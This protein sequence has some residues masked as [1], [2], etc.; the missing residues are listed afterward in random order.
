[1]NEHLQSEQPYFPELHKEII[2]KCTLFLIDVFPEFFD[3]ILY[4]LFSLGLPQGLLPT[5]HPK[6]D[7]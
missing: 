6:L 5:G 7:D 1:M 3:H 2:L 4:N